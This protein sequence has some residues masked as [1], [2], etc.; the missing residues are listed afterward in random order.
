MYCVDVNV[1]VQACVAAS[2]R[3]QLA[4]SWLLAHRASPEG[5]GLFSVVVSGFFRVATDRRVF[6]E[7]IDPAA[8]VAFIDSLTAS[9]AVSV[10]DP[11]PRHWSLFRQM[12]LEYQPSSA[13]MTDVYL[14]AAA[15]ELN[16]TWVSFDR[17]FARFKKLR[18]LNP[19]D[20]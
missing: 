15:Q 18:W 16:A 11:G 14:A 10:L 12:V 9:T 1:L 20:I 3:H 2:P 17:G 5:L 6:S 19:V 8:A 13:D 7:P 4:R